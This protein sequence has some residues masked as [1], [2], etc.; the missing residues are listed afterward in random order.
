MID[1]QLHHLERYV[2]QQNYGNDQSAQMFTKERRERS[3]KMKELLGQIK[4]NEN[5][6]LTRLV[7]LLS[8]D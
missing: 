4:E 2:L 5:F 3:I 6:F 1:Q 8:G 7:E